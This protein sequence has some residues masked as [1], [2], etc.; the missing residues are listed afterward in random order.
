MTLSLYRKRTKYPSSFVRS[1]VEREVN[2]VREEV[3][4]VLGR[5]FEAGVP[6]MDVHH[7]V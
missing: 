1:V 5:S 3:A 6:K 7:D 2:G 4:E